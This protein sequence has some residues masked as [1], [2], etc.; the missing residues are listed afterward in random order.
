MLTPFIKRLRLAL[1][2]I[3]T[4][5]TL[6]ILSACGSQPAVGEID[7][8]A[9]IALL[10]YETFAGGLDGVVYRRVNRF[11]MLMAQSKEPL[12][13]VFYSPLSDINVQIM[14]RLEQ[15][16][17]EYHDR[18]GI[19]WVDAAAEPALAESFKVESLPQFTVVVDSSVK[20]SLV[21]YDDEGALRLA[22]LLKPYLS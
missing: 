12:L 16:A 13:V 4:L 11:S 3:I 2:L 1:V 15:L 6:A 19:V 9:T 14:P 8:S 18:L 5:M 21:G 17:F 22:E 20:R 7:D 10:S